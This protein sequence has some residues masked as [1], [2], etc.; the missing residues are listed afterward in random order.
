MYH[1]KQKLKIGSL[2]IVEKNSEAVYRVRN[3]KHIIEYILPIFDTYPLLTQKHYQY[4][5]FK[6]ALFI[7]NDLTLSFKEKDLLL[8]KLK[9][10]QNIVPENYRSPA[11]FNTL[12]LLNSKKDAQLI[13]SKMWLVGFVEA[14]GSFYLT[15]KSSNRLVHAFEIT[16]KLDEHVLHAI[17]LILEI[18][19]KVRRKKTHFSIV[20]YKKET[21][22]LLISYFFKTMKGMKSL[23]Y[24]I[25]ARSFNKK[26]RGF[27]YLL[28]IREKMRNIQLI[29]FDL[30]NMVKS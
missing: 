20:A 11:W 10:Q 6:K 23:E 16:Q 14:E 8:S 27:N 25:W 22:K 26:D 9:E 29:R 24:R 28:K 5:N 12:T 2:S 21:I 15:K 4:S 19:T 17:S 18:K 13:I 1:I 30:I 7:L 3:K